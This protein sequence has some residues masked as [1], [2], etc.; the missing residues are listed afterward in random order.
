LP[1]RLHGS[2][3][4]VVFVVVPESAA[5]SAAG[6]VV[7]LVAWETTAVVVV[8]VV[9]GLF[10][11]RSAPAVV[12]RE[13]AGAPLF[14]ECFGPREGAGASRF[15]ECIGPSCVFFVPGSAAVRAAGAAGTL[16]S[17]GA[18]SRQAS[19]MNTFASGAAGKLWSAGA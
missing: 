1:L 8:V 12:V 15:G 13:S 19:G 5:G 6:S 3:A 2:A 18:C 4:V 10:V 14:G 16:W 11:E 9:A 17:A 7:F